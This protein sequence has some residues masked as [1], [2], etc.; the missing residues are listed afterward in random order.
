MSLVGIVDGAKL[1]MY[2]NDHP[3]PHFHVLYAEYRAVIDIQTMRLSRGDL[4][5]GKLRAII[6]WAATRRA[7]L[8]EAWNITQQNLVPEKIP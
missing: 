4:P 3:P 7:N 6:K 1:Y 8:I 5:R 2:A